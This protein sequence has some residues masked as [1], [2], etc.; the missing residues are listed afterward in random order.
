MPLDIPHDRP[1]SPGRIVGF[2]QDLRRLFPQSLDR[3][4]QTW[5]RKPETHP[6][7]RLGFRLLWIDFENRITQLRGVMFGPAPMTVL[8]KSQP[9]RGIKIGQPMHVHRT[10]NKQI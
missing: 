2:H 7:R 9:E 10:N 5:H 8:L 4:F 1:P 6:G 3:L